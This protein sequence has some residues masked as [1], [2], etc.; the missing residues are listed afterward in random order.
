MTGLGEAAR[1]AARGIRGRIRRGLSGRV[2]PPSDALVLVYHSVLEGPASSRLH[3]VPP[4]IL[5]RQLEWLRERFDVLPLEEIVRRVARGGPL[6]GVAAV[7]FD[8]GHASVVREALPILREL[9]L[10]GTLFLTTHLLDGGVYWR[11][12]VRR[13]VDQG[14]VAPFLEFAVARAPEAASIRPERFYHDTKDA[15]RVAS[16]EV[17][18][19][20]E[21][22]LRARDVS[23]D[24]EDP[25]LSWGDLAALDRPGLEVGNH[26]RHHFVMASLTPEA[27]RAEIRSAR[28]ALTRSGL[29]LSTA[30][31][32]P[33]GSPGSYDGATL[34]AAREEGYG[35]VLLSGA[36]LPGRAVERS[37]PTP[38]LR[39]FMPGP[40]DLPL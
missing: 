27:Q 25:H 32:V 30:F 35:L 2:S 15:S 22:F 3:R 8:D 38:V 12:R 40:D 33:F 6:R 19:L 20:L 31:A 5:R 29:T 39:R 37:G 11:E 21:E 18:R 13:V 24:E 10:P 14:L 9:D 28:E 1:K 4:A 34:E 7:T 16:S 23:L 26:S 36:R 17:A